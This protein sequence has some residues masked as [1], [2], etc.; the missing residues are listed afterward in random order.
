M[1]EEKEKIDQKEATNGEKERDVFEFYIRIPLDLSNKLNR[2]F[3]KYVFIWLH[4][5]F[6]EA[7]RKFDLHHG[8]IFTCSIWGLVP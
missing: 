3:K 7:H 1:F 8:G 2:L 4:L 6:V 5:V